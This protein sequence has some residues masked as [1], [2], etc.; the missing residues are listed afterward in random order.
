[1][2]LHTEKYLDKP[3][4]DSIK[5]IFILLVFYSHIMPYLREEN[6]YFDNLIVSN[7]TTVAGFLG[8][9]IVVMF[10]F[11]SGY[12]V[13]YSVIHKGEIYIYQMPIKRILVTF[14]NFAIA[15]F[16]YFVLQSV[17]FSNSYDIS[18]L[19]LSLI[20]WKSLGNSNWY[21]FTILSCYL[22]S[23]LCLRLTSKTLNK[24]NSIANYYQNTSIEKSLH[25][26]YNNYK[27]S[28]IQITTCTVVLIVILMQF[29]PGWWYNTLLAYPFGMYWCLYRQKLD[30]IIK[31]HYIQLLSSIVLI[32]IYV[33]T[34][35]PISHS[36]MLSQ[37]S[38]Y[39]FCNLYIVSYR[40]ISN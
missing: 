9:L 21:I 2:K 8:Q 14:L 17:C 1:M 30:K 35:F 25:E 5:G 38:Q 37:F 13:M 29:K 4:C 20:G 22:I 3:V 36:L 16:V 7:V 33:T 40:C 34:I 12:G 24:D 23:Y 19:L 6:I 26:N 32:Y 11:Y 27:L 31:K 10:F 18:H 15:V 39:N 28:L